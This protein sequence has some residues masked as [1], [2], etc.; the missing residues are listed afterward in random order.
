[1]KWS[2]SVIKTVLIAVLVVHS[3]S[4][5]PEPCEC[6][7]LHGLN[8]A[9]CTEKNITQVPIATDTTMQAIILDKNDMS[10]FAEFEFY[11]AKWADVRK[12]SLKFCHLT[13]FRGEVFSGLSNLHHLDLSH[14][15]LTSLQS[16]QFP[17]LPELRTLDLSDNSITNIHTDSFLGIGENLIRIDLSG[18]KLTFLPWTAVSHLP[19]IKQINLEMN[20]WHCDCHL[21]RLYSE[22]TTRNISPG[23]QVCS[24][25]LTC[26]PTVSLLPIQAVLPGQDVSLHCQVEGYPA[27]SVTW[28]KDGHTIVH[29]I[30]VT[31]S[32]NVGSG[33]ISI[34]SI[35]NITTTSLGL[36]SCL[37]SNVEGTDEKEQFV[38]FHIVES[39]VQSLLIVILISVITTSISI[40][41]VFLITLYC[42]RRFQRRK[43]R[44]KLYS[45]QKPGSYGQISSQNISGTSS[46]QSYLLSETREENISD[47]SGDVENNHALDVI[48]G[49]LYEDA[50]PNIC[51]SM[52]TTHFSFVKNISTSR[53]RASV[54]SSST[55]S[56][57]TYAPY[58]R[59]GYVTL[60][61][62]PKQ[63]PALVLDDGL[64][65][66]TSAD[67]SSNSNICQ[68]HG[69]S[70]SA[71]NTIGLPLPSNPADTMMHMRTSTP[72]TS[73]ASEYSTT[74]ST[75]LLHPI[76]E[77]E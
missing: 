23:D 20:P 18:N 44:S 10:Y 68:L 61:R 51:P 74:A 8:T 36:Y 3:V 66:R 37:A 29:D 27:P 60:P 19:S 2:L 25:S 31:N 34:L 49:S 56:E 67:G 63:R 33:I 15:S 9:D 24:G 6:K 38:D 46:T 30:R 77:Q 21:G 11:N 64:G 57:S 58:P 59:P 47:V 26:P 53:S 69:S 13:S 48:D 42:I 65:P 75:A 14:N 1:M 54:R 17:A 5:C 39:D 28:S 32:D 45:G 71:I 50:N 70:I 73:L 72:N 62:R 43:T 35:T 16:S 7:W 4:P 40:I 76:P 52:N 55:L 41:S 22:L 12:I